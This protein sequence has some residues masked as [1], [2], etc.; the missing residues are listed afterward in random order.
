MGVS[1]VYAFSS[2][3]FPVEFRP[4]FS[5]LHPDVFPALLHV[6]SFVASWTFFFFQEFFVPGGDLGRWSPIDL[7]DSDLYFT[8]LFSLPPWR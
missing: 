2:N 7:S 1:E 6:G 5:A 4:L 3:F 8:I